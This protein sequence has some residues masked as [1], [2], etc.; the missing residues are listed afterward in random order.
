[1]LN[2]RKLSTLLVLLGLTAGAIAALPR[3]Y[4]QGSDANVS[5]AMDDSGNCI[6]HYNALVKGAKAA[7]IKGDRAGAIHSLVAARTELRHCQQLEE[8]E[9]AGETALAFNWP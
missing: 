8:R 5:P 4:A 3:L 7:L 9:A 2:K 6:D 1:M